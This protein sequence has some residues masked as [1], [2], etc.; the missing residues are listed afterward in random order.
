MIEGGRRNTV[1]VFSSVQPR[2]QAAA[3]AYVRATRS[4][5]QSSCPIAFFVVPRKRTQLVVASHSKPQWSLYQFWC[6]ERFDPP[7]RLGSHG[8]VRP[9]Q[10]NTMDGPS[11]GTNSAGC[12]HGARDFSAEVVVDSLNSSVT[13]DNDIGRHDEWHKSAVVSSI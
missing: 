13:P 11:A 5:P 6:V 10:L 7:R 2:I 3:H 1:R 8:V 12:A 4:N 9:I